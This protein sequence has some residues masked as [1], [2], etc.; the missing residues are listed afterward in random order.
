MTQAAKRILDQFDALRDV[1]RAEV[2]AELLRRAKQGEH[3]LPTAEDLTAAADRVFS[4][5]DRREQP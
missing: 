3:D 2:L 5:L 4:D 1:E